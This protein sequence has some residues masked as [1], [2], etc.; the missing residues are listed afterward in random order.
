[1]PESMFLCF[2]FMTLKRLSRLSGGHFGPCA[3]GGRLV[4]D[5]ASIKVVTAQPVRLTA[6]RAAIDGSELPASQQHQ[7]TTVLKMHWHAIDYQLAEHLC[8]KVI[9]SIY[10][11]F[12]WEY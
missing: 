4:L 2:R 3:A 7:N 1:M 10:V 9:N 12:S 5:T 11:K 6:W 8:K